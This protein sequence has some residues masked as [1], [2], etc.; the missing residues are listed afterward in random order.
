M[1]VIIGAAAVTGLALAGLIPAVQASAHHPA[2]TA[3]HQAAAAPVR[4]QLTAYRTATAAQDYRWCVIAR[5]SG[6][7]PYAVNPSSGAGGLFQFQPSTWASLGYYGAPQDA[8]LATQYAAFQ[9]LYAESQ[10]ASD[11]KTRRALYVKMQEMI[12]D[13]APAVWL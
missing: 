1:K 8:S 9:K 12:A 6:G 7:N 11:D 10:V 3:H 4:A 5:E 13:E 2:Q